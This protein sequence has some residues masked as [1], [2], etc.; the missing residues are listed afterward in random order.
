MA[1]NGRLTS[2]ELA[3]VWTGRPARMRRGGCAA[4]M[5]TL[6]LRL[7]HETGV[8]RYQSNGPDSDYRDIAGQRRMRA[9]W[10][11]VGRC[12]N[13]AVPGYS[14]HGWAI[15]TDGQRWK[16]VQYGD[17][18]GWGGCTDAPWE[19]WHT[20]WCGGYKRP[21]PGPDPH[22]PILRAGSGGV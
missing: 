22:Y 10:C 4:G 11:G 2:R 15:A 6:N 5:N 20:K 17:P 13:A 18:F 16:L 1:A 3:P 19:S 14:N 7:Y 9:Y 21:D 8:G 12:G